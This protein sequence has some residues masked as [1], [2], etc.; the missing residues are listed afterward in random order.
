M[1]LPHQVD[2]TTKSTLRKVAM[3][4]AYIWIQH[5]KR[6]EV[7]TMKDAIMA[8]YGKNIYGEKMFI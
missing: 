6:N 4:F 8:T 2:I 3:K 5:G 1:A 7:Y